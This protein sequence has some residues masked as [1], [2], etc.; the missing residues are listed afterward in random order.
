MDVRQYYKQ[1]PGAVRVSWTQDAE[2]WGPAC[3]LRALRPS[4]THGWATQP[5]WGR[6]ATMIARRTL[7]QN[8][9]LSPSPTHLLHTITITLSRIKCERLYFYKEVYS[10]V[11]WSSYIMFD[12]VPQIFVYAYVQMYY[13]YTTFGEKK[14]KF[15]PALLSLRL[16]FELETHR[17]IHTDIHR[18]IDT[19]TH[20]HINSDTHRDTETYTYTFE[21]FSWGIFSED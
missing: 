16:D 10:F 17:H 7:G 21:T 15:K 14:T 5:R 6:S 2:A 3:R 18:Y 19:N 20:R 4:V 8:N 1:V 11:H 9:S 12:Y 13:G